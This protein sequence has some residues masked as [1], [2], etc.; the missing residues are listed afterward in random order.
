MSRRAFVTG[1]TGFVG[2]NLIA[3]LQKAD[4][5]IFALHRKSSNLKYLSQFQVNLVEASIDNEQELSSIF[6]DDIDV[7]FHVA[8][9]TSVWS[10]NNAQ[11]YRDNVIGTKNMVQC[12]IDKNVD[13]F[14]Y[15]SSI[16]AYGIHGTCIKEDTSSNAE[17]CGIHYN[18]T[19]Y[20]AEKEIQQGVKNGLNAVIINPIH[21]VGKYDSS[22]WAQI[23]QAVYN[24][25]LP[26]IPSGSGMFCNVKDVVKAHIAAID[27]GENGENYLLG[28]PEAGFKE[29]I[30]VVQ[31]I[32]GMKES[33][34]VTPN[35][36]LKLGMHL[37]M[38]GS[39]FTSKE[40]QLTPEKFEMITGKMVCDYSKAEREL[41]YQTTDL[42]TSLSESYEWLKQ[43]NL[44]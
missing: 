43:E 26:G 37:F 35:W 32:L 3:E 13:K 42:K 23:V 11:Q 1:G 19:K 2:L 29:V 8:S 39:A 25:N 31:K 17:S 20:L 24:N 27:K 22:N 38:F 7:V 16:A 14:I 33:E 30:N 5:E 34:K 41:G 21:I 6:P 15:T 18:K 12:A 36:V 10:M 9:N 28:G 44:L 40:P 4:W